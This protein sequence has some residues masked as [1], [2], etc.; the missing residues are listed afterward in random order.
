VDRRR[1]R[2]DAHHDHGRQLRRALDLSGRGTAADRI[3]DAAGHAPHQRV[4][5]EQGFRP[6]QVDPGSADKRL[7]GVRIEPA[8]TETGRK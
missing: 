6:S 3:A 4:R 7:L 8:D 1:R 5:A 2:G